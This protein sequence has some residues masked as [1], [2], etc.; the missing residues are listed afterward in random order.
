MHK[1]NLRKS[2]LAVALLAILIF[3]C[4]G[5]SG[6]SDLSGDNSN[7]NTSSSAT[8]APGPTPTPTAS[9]I[10]LASSV[11]Y[12]EPVS[13]SE[14]KYIEV[15]L[16][17]ALTTDL[18]LYLTTSDINAR[19]SGQFKNYTAKVAEEYTVAAGQTSAD[20]P[21]IIS[22]N[23]YFEGDVTLTY[24]ISA[25]L[26]SA[27]SI[28]NGQAVVTISDND[29]EP[30]VSF[31]KINR[32]LLE[33]ESDSFNVQLSHYSSLDVLLE[34]TQTGSVNENDFTDSLNSDKSIAINKG[35][36]SATFSVTA[37]K[38]N[39]SEGAESL[40][41]TL[42]NPT[43]VN[44]D[45]DRKSLSIYIPGDKRFNDT[46]FVTRFDGT[47]FDSTGS[48]AD[49]PNQDADFGS[50]IAPSMTHTD[51]RYGFSYSKFD[52]HGNSLPLDALQYACIRD[53]TTGLYIENK[54][55]ETVILPASEDAVEAEQDALRDDPDNYV[56]P[57]DYQFA[58][59]NWQNDS[60]T[61]TWYEE[62][63]DLNGGT[64]G[65][66]NM[67][68][69]EKVP[70][71]VTC[72][73]A[74]NSSGNRRCDTSGYLSQM[75][76]FAVCGFTDWRLPTPTEMKSLISFN[77]DDNDQN[78]RTFLTFIQDKTYFTSATNAERTGAAWCVN[79]VT[80]QAKLCLKGSHNSVIAVSGGKE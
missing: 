23:N 29:G 16:S 25:P 9:K 38:D 47:D 51:G 56:Y 11:N 64:L 57:A 27:Y 28:E 59:L 17:E 68:M 15:T 12:A 43:D 60:Y 72:A 69:P 42:S 24:S 66:E 52:M 63:N 36:L 1:T 18:T 41:Y 34:L 58:S 35:E 71:D 40:I 39:I 54:P 19:S 4:K 55:S 2:T 21:L 46:G 5:G 48:Q 44:L 13:G 45:S 8:P 20:L 37:V 50:D 61:Y 73:I 78:N 74:E 53:N 22:N 77:A 65:A 75:N 62:D 7:N 6:G 14:T 30:T 80:G 70:V 33:D 67:T 3:G 26:N 31:G 79:T 49:Y 76:R 10:N 32:T